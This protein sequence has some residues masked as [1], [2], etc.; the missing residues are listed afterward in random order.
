MLKY[1]KTNLSE[2]VVISL[3]HKHTHKGVHISECS[4]LAS[5]SHVWSIETMLSGK[6]KSD[7]QTSE[8][9]INDRNKIYTANIFEKCFF[10]VQI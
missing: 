4:A 1:S 2:T 7:E 3:Q 5:P 9:G 8:H 6:Q 10:T